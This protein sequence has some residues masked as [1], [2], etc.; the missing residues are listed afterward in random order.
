MASRDSFPCSRLLAG[1]DGICLTI[2]A[3]RLVARAADAAGGGELVSIAGVFP[4]S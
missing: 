1:R 4:I 3:G 2:V